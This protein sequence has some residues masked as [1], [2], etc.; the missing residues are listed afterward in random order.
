MA[1]MRNEL[2]LLQKK[3]LKYDFSFQINI[4]SFTEKNVV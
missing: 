4:F 3:S 1:L 2:P